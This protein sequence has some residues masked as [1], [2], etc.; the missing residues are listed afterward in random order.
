MLDSDA[1]ASSTLQ[2]ISKNQIKFF[3]NGIKLLTLVTYYGYKR[4]MLSLSSKADYLFTKIIGAIMDDGRSMRSDP[5]VVEF[6]DMIKAFDKSG[7]TIARVDKNL[8]NLEF[9][10]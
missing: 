8:T 1:G 9:K 10:L 3:T 7:K 2:S 6:R 5:K 4:S